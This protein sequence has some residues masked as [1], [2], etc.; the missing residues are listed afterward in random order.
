LLPILESRDKR[1][2][3]QTIRN[4]ARR[5]DPAAVKPL[6]ELMNQQTLEFGTVEVSQSLV[7]LAGSNFGYD[8]H[9]WG[10]QQ[11][12]NAHAIEQFKQWIA[13]NVTAD[14]N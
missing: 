6:L 11:P 10:P 9:N 12:K 4:F 5:K 1:L 8:I 14:V 13:Q 7:A 2:R 3:V